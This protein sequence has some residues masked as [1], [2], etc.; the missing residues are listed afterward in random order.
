V[1]TRTT[2]FRARFA[3]FMLALPALVAN[4][5]E[6]AVTVTGSDGKPLENS[7]VY[8]VPANPG[9]GLPAPKKAE[10][11]QVNKTFIPAVTVIQTGAAVS[12]PN[13]DNIRHQVYSFSP[14]RVFN[15]KLYSG[16]PS[17]PVVFDKPGVVV[18]GCNIHD[19]MVAWVVVVDTP[20]FSRSDADG[21]AAV[22]N[23]PAG[24]YVL[25]V[26]HSA[27]R[28]PVTRKLQLAEGRTDEAFQ[29]DA[30]SPVMQDHADHGAAP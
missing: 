8:A 18:L 13:S 3:G 16:R 12:F 28:E 11:D 20:W 25:N 10:I 17:E 1:I 21:R 14:A 30:I 5:T 7:V 6:L 23:L 15:T 24:D 29:L 4:A 22:K 2:R 27:L 19:K 26:W 9:T